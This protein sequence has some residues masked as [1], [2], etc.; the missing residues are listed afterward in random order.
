MSMVTLNVGVTVL[1]RCFVGALVVLAF[2]CLNSETPMVDGSGS[3][4]PSDPMMTPDAEVYNS[5]SVRVATFNVKRFFDPNCD[6]QRCSS[7]SYEIQPSQSEFDARAEQLATGIRL[8]ESDVV[9]LQEVESDASLEAISTAL[10]DEYF[11]LVMGETGRAASLDVAILARLPMIDRFSHVEEPIELVN[12]PGF[13]YF[14]RE[15]LEVHF[16]FGASRLIVFNAHFR[17]KRPPDDP[18]Q[19]LA[20]AS[21]AREIILERAASFPDALVVFGGDLN[22][23]PGSAPLNAL[24]DGNLLYRVSEELGDDAGTYIYRGNSQ[25]ID[26]LYVYENEAGSYEPG[27]ARVVRNSPLGLA[28]SDHGGLTAGFQLRQQ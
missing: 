2:G 27:T 26:H 18:G 25:A 17:S 7:G 16:E 8:L 6:S 24:E 20:E 22:D 4:M 9:L 19:R 21:A 28:G 13:T 15:F 11:T 5:W 1:R 23:L 3:D 10:N 14:E 12:Q